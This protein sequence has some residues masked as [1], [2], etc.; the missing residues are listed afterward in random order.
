MVVPTVAWLT[1]TYLISCAPSE[2]RARAEALALE[3]SVEM[4]LAAVREQRVR[5]EIV[6]RLDRIEPAPG[7]R[8]RVALRLALATTGND[9]AQLLNMLFGNCSLQDDVQL[10]D[11]A[12]PD[13]LVASLSGPRFGIAGLRRLTGV[14]ARPLTCTALKPQGSSPA[15]LARLCATFAA[16]GIDIVKD[17]H[18]LANQASA[19]F[20]ERVRACSRA[21]EGTATLY[22]PSIVGAPRAL[23]E[24]ARI[25]REEGVRI[26]LVAPMLVGLPA[27]RELV[28][29]FADLAILGHPAF[30]GAARI[31]PAWLFGRF[32]RLLGA[33][34]VIYPNYGGR[35]AYSPEVCGD[36][37]RA[38]R[39]PWGPVLP[40]MPVPAG[41]MSLERIDEMVGFYGPDTMLLIGGALLEA[42]NLAERSRAFV[43]KVSAA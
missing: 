26:V 24:Q 20:A 41:G 35:F 22:A 12:L 40:A 30:G 43:A 17:D 10:E 32:Y 6:G 23:F 37:A 42:E 29:A 11:V 21:V 8:F 15:E 9:V 5:D 27:F 14:A 7:G 2:V 28:E 1:S 38:A 39:A 19:P 4:P 31:S 33:D 13:E 3:Q 25:A 34:A 18:G 16:A 36:L